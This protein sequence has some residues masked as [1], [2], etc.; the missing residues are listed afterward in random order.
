MAENPIFIFISMSK[1][2]R[3]KSSLCTCVERIIINGI[4]LEFN[5]L[6][7]LE[8]FFR[9]NFFHRTLISPQNLRTSQKKE[10]KTHFWWNPSFVSHFS[11]SFAHMAYVVTKWKRGNILW[12]EI[13]YRICS[14][15]VMC[16]IHFDISYIELNWSLGN[17]TTHSVLNSSYTVYHF[18]KLIFEIWIQCT[19]KP[20]RMSMRAMGFF[21]LNIIIFVST[22]Q[23]LALW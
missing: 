14:W 12:N 18:A 10:N 19:A 11:L 9:F 20:E 15:C 17:R 7:S 13:E 2:Q 3:K 8:L 22:M 23:W 5:E 16:M 4:L 6:L 1:E 21:E